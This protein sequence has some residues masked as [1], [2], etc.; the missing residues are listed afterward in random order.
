MEIWQWGPEPSY[1]QLMNLHVQEEYT[2]YKE[3]KCKCHLVDT[4]D[5]L[6]LREF[7]DKFY[8]RINY[9]FSDC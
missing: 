2:E 9:E 1:N 6:S 4:C 5:C 8:M 7:E 3:K